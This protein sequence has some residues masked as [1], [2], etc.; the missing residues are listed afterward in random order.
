[1]LVQ[2]APSDARP[3]NPENPIQNKP[4]V[5]RATAAPGPA[6]DH[7]R[8]KAGPFLV[9]HQTA[10]QN[11]LRKS[12]VESEPDAVGNPLCQHGLVFGFPIFAN[13]TRFAFPCASAPGWPCRRCFDYK[14]KR[15]QIRQS[16]AQKTGPPL[17]VTPNLSTDSRPDYCGV[18]GPLDTGAGA[19]LK[20]ISTRRFC[21]SRTPS[22]V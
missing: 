12:H 6:L 13:R 4:V 2:I 10:Y 5:P 1:M 21:G 7:K 8:L 22:A 9:A 18:Q 14:L 19:P 15:R 17:R 11:G 20:V 16:S 3:R